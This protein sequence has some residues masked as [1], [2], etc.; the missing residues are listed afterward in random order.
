MALTEIFSEYHAGVKSLH[1]V[2]YKWKNHENTQKTHLLDKISE[3]TTIYWNRLKG[4][5]KIA[6][7]MQIYLEH[8]LLNCS[9]MYWKIRPFLSLK[10]RPL[11][12]DIIHI[13]SYHWSFSNI[14][15]Q[16]FQFK[17]NHWFSSLA[18]VKKLINL[19]RR[20]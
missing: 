14:G 16:Y 1:S 6:F 2:S 10:I 5:V 9:C 3:T 11:K 18:M 13:S 15:H 7:K 19:N 12:F 8:Q 20:N 4:M 17:V